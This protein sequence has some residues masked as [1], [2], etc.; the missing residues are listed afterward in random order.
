MANFWKGNSYVSGVDITGKNII[1]SVDTSVFKFGVGVG[2]DPVCKYSWNLGGVP[3]IIPVLIIVSLTKS[4]IT[5]KTQVKI[6][7]CI[8][9]YCYN[10]GCQNVCCLEFKEGSFIVR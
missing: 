10:F 8:S 9:G 1:V 4:C 5:L 3:I 2:S 7:I 6:C